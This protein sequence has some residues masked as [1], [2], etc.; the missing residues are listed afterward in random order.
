MIIRKIVFITGTVLLLLNISGLFL[1]L[2]NPDIYQEQKVSFFEDISLTAQ[3]VYSN[4][5]REER[6]PADRFV[7]RIN[8][9]IN[10]GIAHYWVDEGI[11]KYNLRIPVWEN[12]LL[13]I[14]SFIDPEHYKKYEFADYVKA[15]ERG[16]GLCSQHAIIVTGI[17][18]A[19]G[20]EAEMIG[21][22]GHVVLRAKIEEGSWY[23]ADPDYGTVIP[24]DISEIEDNP[25]IIRPS[26]RNLRGL[27]HVN[28]IEPV[29]DNLV[30]IFGKEG[31]RIC[32]DGIRGYTGSEKFNRE[33]LSY[34]FIW[35]IPIIMLL[36]YTFRFL[37]NK[38]TNIS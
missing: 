7:L 24:H 36:P 14:S 5:A 3:E 38:S 18:N 28:D 16:V 2:R 30:D 19:N 35:I 31:N 26:Y 37:R 8:D 11:E 21:L 34:I 6:E 13:Y 32:K 23:V 15:I 33:Y 4:I 22:S 9:L 29:I 27:S 20:I 1:S 25:E 17:L 12:Y 10:R